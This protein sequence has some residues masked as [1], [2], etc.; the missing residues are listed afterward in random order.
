ME[1]IEKL[2][3]DILTELK[4]M[5]GSKL[6]EKED[7]ECMQRNLHML[8]SDRGRKIFCEG[9]DIIYKLID[10]RDLDF[11]VSIRIEEYNGN[12]IQLDPRIFSTDY[13]VNPIEDLDE[14]IE[15]ICY[16]MLL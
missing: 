14:V 3:E 9:F 2:L 16:G 1:R 8:E 15:D 6:K 4:K 10:K 5:N 7:K 11:R 13:L 12:V